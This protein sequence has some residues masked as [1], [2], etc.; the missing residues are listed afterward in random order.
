MGKPQANVTK[1][2]KWFGFTL[3]PLKQVALRLTAAACHV[4]A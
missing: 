4:L 1:A 3:M 2:G